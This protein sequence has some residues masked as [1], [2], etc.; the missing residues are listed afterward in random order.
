MALSF[1]SVVPGGPDDLVDPNHTLPG[2]I[3]ESPGARGSAA[4]VQG[5]DVAPLL[6][7]RSSAVGTDGEL[8]APEP[9]RCRYGGPPEGF[10]FEGPSGRGSAAG[11]QDRD[12]APLLGGES[13]A[14]GADGE[15]EAPEP[16]MELEGLPDVSRSDVP[17]H[18]GAAGDDAPPAPRTSFPSNSWQLGRALT[19]G[20]LRTILTASWQL[21]RRSMTS[22]WQ[23]G[24]RS[25]T[26]SWQLCLTS[27]EYLVDILD[28]EEA[29][30]VV[31]DPIPQEVGDNEGAEEGGENRNQEEAAGRPDAPAINDLQLVPCR[32]AAYCRQVL[33]PLIRTAS[34]GFVLGA[35][36]SAVAHAL[37]QAPSA[38]VLAAAAT[39]AH[40]STSV[41]LQFVH[42]FQ[43]G[44]IAGWRELRLATLASVVSVTI[45]VAASTAIMNGLTRHDH[46][47]R[48]NFNIL[49]CVLSCIFIWGALASF[50]GALVRAWSLK[51]AT[52]YQALGRAQPTAMQRLLSSLKQAAVTSILFLPVMLFLWAVTAARGLLREIEG[53]DHFEYLYY[54][55][56]VLTMLLKV[57]IQKALVSLAGW[58]PRAKVQLRH[59]FFALE[60]IASMS[61]KLVL[62]STWKLRPVVIAAAA[63]SVLEVAVETF[64][65]RRAY[66]KMQKQ[67]EAGWTNEK[68]LGA[69]TFK[70]Q[71]CFTKVL[72][73]YVSIV[74]SILMAAQLSHASFMP[75][76]HVV[77]AKWEDVPRFLAAQLAQELVAD[78]WV[79]AVWRHYGLDFERLLWEAPVTETLSRSLQIAGAV[80]F[81]VQGAVA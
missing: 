20:S 36:G 42:L 64:N 29:E 59:S 45:A 57:L 16:S 38:S 21:G 35:L 79:L 51:S 73:E 56:V 65:I 68:A 26:S 22:S 70:A 63:S 3:L 34:L 39:A 11:A 50:S 7:G 33:V 14:V 41:L 24:R 9:H 40:L 23:L 2:L 28:S 81:C 61:L 52:F 43:N 4:N 1:C 78:F 27:M 31:E 75:S 48:K 6:Y 47:Q 77:G 72:V 44:Y 10:I 37:D 15:L 17:V 46:W 58:S 25:M 19:R 66:L 60:C 8:Q 62:N 5:R 55:A 80:T 18:G 30:A 54:V 13:S 32:I 74:F 71:I 12:A 76:L 69:F 49:A 53:T 67:R